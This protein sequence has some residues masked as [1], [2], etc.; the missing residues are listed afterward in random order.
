MTKLLE[1][2]RLAGSDAVRRKLRVCHLAYTFY[3]TDNRVMRYAKALVERGDD[4]EVI[5]LR[6]PNQS[7]QEI[8]RGVR[9][10]RLQRR[11]KTE[12]SVWSHLCKIGWFMLQAFVVLGAR[13]LRKR[14]DVVHVHN[15]PDFLVWA[16]LLP[17]LTGARVV[18]DIHDVLPELYASKF[19]GGQQSRAFRLLLAVER[20]S[21]RFAD[22]VIVAN[23]IWHDRLVKRA[24]PSNKCLTILNYPDLRVFTPRRHVAGDDEKFIILYPGSLSRHQGLDVA[25][26]AFAAAGEQLGDAEFHIYGEGP[27]KADLVELTSQLGLQGRVKIHD[28]LPVDEIA[29]VMASAAVGVEPKLAQGFG[30][31]ALSTKILEFMASGVPVIV[32]RT[33]AHAHYFDQTVVRFFPSGDV[34]ELAA[35]LVEAYNRRPDPASTQLA[36]TFAS[37]YGWHRRVGDY[38]HLLESLSG[39]HPS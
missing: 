16:A 36:R 11:A 7:R 17:K 18:L 2:D 1:N 22:H 28:P 33:L 26:R 9:V 27:A 4:V 8:E 38:Y 39:V 32:S 20:L 3:E 23:H 15:Q 34:E 31:E 14:Y 37:N 24:A 13:H 21:C 6:R 12:G 30:N 29:P 19:G 25:I 35:A 10:V 5:A